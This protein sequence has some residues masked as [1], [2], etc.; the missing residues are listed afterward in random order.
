MLWEKRKD[1]K[2]REKPFVPC[3]SR[4]IEHSS[5]CKDLFFTEGRGALWLYI[6]FVSPHLR[7]CIS[8]DLA[9]DCALCIQRKETSWMPFPPTSTHRRAEV[10]ADRHC[11]AQRCRKTWPFP[12]KTALK[13]GNSEHCLETRMLPPFP[14]AQTWLEG[15]AS[16]LLNHPGRW[17]QL[18]LP[19]GAG[20]FFWL[21]CI[22]RGKSW[23]QTW[24]TQ[25]L[26]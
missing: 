7:R 17:I 19:R 24:H 5:L 21:R 6:M 25:I 22:F 15:F 9:A 3:R 1:T 12:R 20:S 26:A 23:K 4:R 11:S 8:G 13:K 18:V 2:G 10:R 16:I 14:G